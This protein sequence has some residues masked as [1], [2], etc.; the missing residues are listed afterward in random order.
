MVSTLT[1]ILVPV[2]AL[3][4]IGGF[5]LF[6]IG[7]DEELRYDY[8]LEL[9]DSF[10]GYNG[11]IIKADEG[12]QFAIVHVTGYNKSVAGG[13]TENP[14]I[15]EWNLVADGITYTYDMKHYRHPDHGEDSRE[16]PMGETGSFVVVFQVIKTLSADDIT[17][18]TAYTLGNVN[19]IYDDTLIQ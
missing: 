11:D 15:W 7:A 17:V 1:K 4:A 5:C 19:T 3:V 14:Y 10:I 18:K 8:E 13:A 6:V 2:V 9:T 12:K 16:I